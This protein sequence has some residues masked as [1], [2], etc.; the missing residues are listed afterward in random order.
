M[1]RKTRI[2]TLGMMLGT[3]LLLGAAVDSQ[4]QG[5]TGALVRLLTVTS[6]DLPGSIYGAFLS[7]DGNRLFVW[8]DYGGAGAWD[9]TTGERFLEDELAGTIVGPIG[10]PPLGMTLSTDE[11]RL[12]MVTEREAVV[13]GYAD[14]TAAV[15]D[16][17]LH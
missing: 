5:Q 2:L 4:K 13:W 12:L 1:T 16:Y 9:V 7:T 15:R 3:A 17:T 8:D 14:D 6:Q 10:G 11:T